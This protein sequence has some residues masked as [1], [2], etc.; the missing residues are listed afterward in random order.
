MK[1]T[2]ILLGL[3]LAA[4][5]F[6][7]DLPSGWQWTPGFD[8]RLHF[9]VLVLLLLLAGR[10]IY[11]SFSERA[12]FL[13]WL[14][15]ACLARSVAGA[16]GAYLPAAAGTAVAGRL[17]PLFD[18]AAGWAVL[19]FAAS[20]LAAPG[21]RG[22][23]PGFA[24][25]IL[26]GAAGW[27]FPDAETVK[28]VRTV[29]LAVFGAAYLSAGLLGAVHL[30]RSP[31]RGAVALFLGVL[32]AAALAW[33]ALSPGPYSGLHA[34]SLLLEVFLLAGG[35]VVLCLDSRRRT[36]LYAGTSEELAERIEADW[37]MIEK[38]KDGK[39]RLEERNLENMSLSG[40]LLDSAQRQAEAIGQIMSAIA[41][42]ATAEDRVV[43][44][45]RQIMNLTAE[46][47]ARIA[48]FD[49]QIRRS[50]RELE[51]LQRKSRIITKAVAQIIGIADKTNMLSLNASIEASKAGDA[52]RGFSVVAHQIRKLA[53]TTRRVSDQVSSL[54]RESNRAVEKNVL[55]A[56]GLQQ[57]YGEIMRQSEQIRAM[58]EDNTRAL[59]EVTRAHQ[60]VQD[61]VAGV[62][63]TIK[64]I[65]E[66]SRD[67]RRM[68]GGL[69]SAFSWFD[70]V[71]RVPGQQG[72]PPEG[73]SA[74]DEPPVMQLPAADA[75]SELSE[76]EELPGAEM[77][78]LDGAPAAAPW[79]QGEEEP[80]EL[81]T[82]PEEEE[83]S[84]ERAG[85]AAE[86]PPPSAGA[87]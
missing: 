39:G 63:L 71:L 36:R 58:I 53:D 59:E 48:E 11:L 35:A 17:F 77:F 66:V 87:P 72:T 86:R 27:L 4:G 37:E 38:L 60:Q 20:Y 54:I 3:L 84:A 50:L 44:M 12:A 47:D 80:G 76:V 41:E 23:A 21:R 29:Q 46:V 10:L 16:L 74:P 25:L 22:L 24:A 55:M 8:E 57:G 7:Q 52:G 65:L 81:P 28:G 75:L 15:L 30:K 79:G 68:T 82:L 33:R 64:T 43:A 42:G 19:A 6:G 31:R 85:P 73:A 56:E 34:S 5:A 67:L 51:E 14:G 9:T 26:V 70:E 45:E 62:D 61:Q 40:R 2:L 13:R 1:R 32:A 49:Q 18:A 83:G 69:A 78:A